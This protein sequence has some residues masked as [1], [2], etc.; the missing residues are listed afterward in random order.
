MQCHIL[1]FRFDFVW[2]KLE[3]EGKNK[4]IL[5]HRREKHE[6]RKKLAQMIMTVLQKGQRNEEQGSCM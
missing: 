5:F 6:Q 3:L 2:N 1:L 4:K